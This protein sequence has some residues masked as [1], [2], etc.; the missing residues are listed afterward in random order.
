MTGTSEDTPRPLLGHRFF[1]FSHPTFFLVICS[2][3]V[4][5]VNFVAHSIS[6]FTFFALSF[7]LAHE[8]RQMFFSKFLIKGKSKMEVVDKYRYIFSKNLLSRPVF[9]IKEVKCNGF[10][11]E[12]IRTFTVMANTLRVRAMSELITISALVCTPHL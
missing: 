5:L 7:L 9:K 8:L 1:S 6:H 10:C 11:F 12:I 3:H 4:P 2:L